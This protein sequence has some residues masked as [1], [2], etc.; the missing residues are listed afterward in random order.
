L[1]NAAGKISPAPPATERRMLSKFSR[2]RTTG[3]KKAKAW[4]LWNTRSVKF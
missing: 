4:M 3:E 1:A 2:T